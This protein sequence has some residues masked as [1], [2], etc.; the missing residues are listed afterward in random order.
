MPR[1]L[2]AEN[3]SLIYTTQRIRTAAVHN[4]FGNVPPTLFGLM[5][6]RYVYRTDR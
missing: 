1:E 6:I 2:I 5:D 4:V 3:V